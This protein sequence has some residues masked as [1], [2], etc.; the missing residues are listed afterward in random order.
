[1]LLPSVAPDFRRVFASV[2]T[3]ALATGD[4][5]P[6]FRSTFRLSSLGRFPAAILR[7]CFVQRLQFLVAVFDFEKHPY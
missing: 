6:V 3:A 5:K 7:P 2:V 1:M 4:I